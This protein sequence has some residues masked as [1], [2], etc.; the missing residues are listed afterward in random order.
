[1]FN[2][3]DQSTRRPKNS[4]DTWRIERST[5]DMQRFP[6]S[7]SN[8][9]SHRH[10]LRR[11]PSD[12]SVASNISTSSS[13]FSTASKVAKFP[14][15]VKHSIVSVKDKI[16][17]TKSKKKSIEH[18]SDSL[19][20]RLRKRT[21]SS[22]SLASLFLSHRRGSTATDQVSTDSLNA[23]P[24]IEETESENEARP[25]GKLLFGKEIGTMEFFE[26][27]FAQSTTSSASTS[28]DFLYHDPDPKTTRSE[29]VTTKPALQD[30]VWGHQRVKSCQ[31]AKATS[32]RQLA[33]KDS[34]R[35]GNPDHRRPPGSDQVTQTNHQQ[36]ST[37]DHPFHMFVTATFTTLRTKL[38]GDCDRVL[39]ALQLSVS[40]E[41]LQDI[42]NG[43]RKMCELVEWEDNYRK[44]VSENLDAVDHQIE[45]I[46]SK[47]NKDKKV[48]GENR[49]VKD[50][51]TS[52][53]QIINQCVCQHYKVFKKAMIIPC[54]GYKI[55]GCNKT[56]ELEADD[57]LR[58][59]HDY[60]QTS[61]EHIDQDARW[62]RNFFLTKDYA[63][64]CG[65]DDGE[66]MLL[67]VVYDLTENHYRIIL[68]TK[69]GPDTRKIVPGSFLLSAPTSERDEPPE[70]AWKG[71]I[72]SAIDVP[73][74]QLKHVD[75]EAIVSSGIENE[76]LKLDETVIHTRYKFGVLYVKEGQTKEEEW[77][78]NQHDSEK[79]DRFLN[80]I[81][82]KV[83]LQGYS[84]WAAGLD[85][86]SGDSGEY[87]YTGE[88]NENTLA[89]HVSTLIPSRSGDKQQIQ[90]KRHIGNEGKQPFNPTAIK[91]QFLHV[92]IVVHE[93][94][95]E[96]QVGWRVEI[97][98][99]QD[100]PD[101]GPPLPP[102]GLFF[103]KVELRSFIL[104]K[105]VNAEYAALKSP[106]FA[107]PMARAREG[108]LTNIV[109]RAWQMVSIEPVSSTSKSA[110]SDLSVDTLSESSRCNSDTDYRC[111]TQEPAE[112]RSKTKQTAQTKAKNPEASE[113]ES[114]LQSSK[115]IARSNVVSKEGFKHRAQNIIMS[116]SN[117]GVRR[118]DN[119]PPM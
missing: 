90:R 104:A 56:G 94:T 66:A 112:S 88:W 21:P 1:M 46:R 3:S 28:H 25:V 52:I 73:F 70:L 54:E 67:S 20:R 109:E 29:H 49:A 117:L 57:T 24:R 45:Q 111:N 77:F 76:I 5:L 30:I 36:I 106:K 17:L 15:A 60:S 55:E 58:S 116:F 12:E 93:E 61:I 4:L 35:S 33:G 38:V 13:I 11:R 108:I 59:A 23:H 85:T 97:V 105:L 69:Q 18:I 91:S 34:G 81:G 6:S 99:V 10:I 95:W 53:K 100:V 101:F 64:F 16:K 68:R 43:L 107:Q 51:I 89:F 84:G 9:S 65:F 79:F 26:Q 72:E 47:L 40:E 87:T 82:T 22:M 98:T 86:K 103:D 32:L 96:E 8:Q 14:H 42:M 31:E 118:S 75:K 27:E 63:T 71:V 83:E 41:K 2:G 37:D 48:V 39:A 62:F 115:S 113:P 114:A 19:P 80:I 50:I 92:F 110:S 7:D 74:Y 119:R 102:K 78:S 44:Q